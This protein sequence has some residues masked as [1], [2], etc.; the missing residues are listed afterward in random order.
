MLATGT[1]IPDSSKRT[2]LTSPTALATLAADVREDARIVFTAHSIPVSM[3]ER[4]LYRRHL[5]ESAAAIA[6][7]L[8]RS[9]FALVYQSRS[10]RPEDPW[11][12]PDI[13]DYLKEEH[14]KGLRA[15]VLCP[16]GF[17]CDHVE[18]LYDLDVEAANVCREIGLPMARASAVND[19]P[20]FI[21]TMADAVIQTVRRYDHARPLQIV[22]AAS[23]RRSN[24]LPVAS[25]PSAS[26]RS[27]QAPSRRNSKSLESRIPI[28]CPE[29]LHP[30][31]SRHPGT[32]SP[33]P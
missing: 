18:V 15:A 5:E 26:R 11:L 31:H 6:A 20:R 29:S 28:R 8:G 33:S 14:H 10:G 23:D 3:A 19:H 12:G 25:V 4:S 22:A 21:D 13:G 30:W 32:R 27:R 2:P 16:V 17:L 9:N 24:Q 1:R 7:R